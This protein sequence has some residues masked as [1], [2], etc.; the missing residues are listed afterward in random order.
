MVWRTI[1]RQQ[2]V[3]QARSCG[4]RGGGMTAGIC[5]LV[6][7]VQYSILHARGC[8]DA[9]Q[10]L[11]RGWLSGAQPGFNK[12]C[13]R[14]GEL[15]SWRGERACVSYDKSMHA[16]GRFQQRASCWAGPGEQ[17]L[18]KSRRLVRAGTMGGVAAQRTASKSLPTRSAHLGRLREGARAQHVDGGRNRYARMHRSCD[19]EGRCRGWP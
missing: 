13:A 12:W 9:D 4:T 6:G 19:R 11:M 7:S 8:S 15:C 2:L 5:E 1:K 10:N 3:R 18:L 17:R 14:S 16:Q